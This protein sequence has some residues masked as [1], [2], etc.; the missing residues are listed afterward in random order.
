MLKSLKWKNKERQCSCNCRLSVFSFLFRFFSA[1]FPQVL[2]SLENLC[3]LLVFFLEKKTNYVNK[4]FEI[5]RTE[6]KCA[7][8]NL[9]CEGGNKGHCFGP[10]FSR[11]SRLSQQQTD[12]LVNFRPDQNG[13][14]WLATFEPCRSP[15]TVAERFPAVGCSLISSLRGTVHPPLALQCIYPERDI[16]LPTPPQPTLA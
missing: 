9:Y 6:T 3:S 2:F 11:L 8:Y 13:G 14:L 1:S 12:M 16:Q 10:K 7:P 15:L 5:D 4:N